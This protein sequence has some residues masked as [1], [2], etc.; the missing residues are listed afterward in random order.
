MSGRT[1]P[2]RL[3]SLAVLLVALLLGACVTT[4]TE[5][6]SQAQPPPDLK[7]RPT[8]SDETDAAKRGRARLELAA[9]Y[10]SR[11]QMQ[12][13][14]DQV[15][16][17]IQADPNSSAAFN[18]RGLIYANLG[19]QALAE[20]SFR[21]ALQLDPRDADAM[22]NYGWYLCQ[23][24]RY[25]EADAMFAQALAVPQYRDAPRTLLAQGV[26]QAFAGNLDKSEATLSRSYELDPNNPATAVNLAEVLYRKG[27]YERARFFV[28]R[29]N[30]QPEVSNAQTLWL[31]ARIEH[32]MGN[33]QGAD[34][35][36]LQLRNRFPQSREASSFQRGAFD[37]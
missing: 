3:G 23:L 12:T 33:Q 34:A 17:A 8:A 22:Q 27:E 35:F 16:L 20:E 1:F 2:N 6:H 19:D 14:L 13:A 7:D 29:V 4:T 32:R 25:P 36:G 5:T 9:A 30:S 26:C 15:K 37:E 10:F 11:G 28:R 21:R 31:A 24:K 18:L